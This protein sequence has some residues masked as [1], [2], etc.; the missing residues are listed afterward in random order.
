M[1]FELVVGA[2]DVGTAEVGVA[3]LVLVKVA[4]EENELEVAEAVQL[5]VL[6]LHDDVHDDVHED[7]HDEEEEE[8]QLPHVPK[9]A[10]QPGPQ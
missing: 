5:L 6:L 10:W 3:A 2:T 4:E 8:D 9:L 1:V 7:D